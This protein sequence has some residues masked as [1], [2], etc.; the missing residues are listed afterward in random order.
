VATWSFR[1]RP[2]RSRPPSSPPTRSISPRSSA[3]CTSSSVTSGW[4]LPSATSE[5]RL[6]SPATRPSRWSSV[7]SPARN[8]TRECAFDAWMS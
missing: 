8:S 7:S 5:A 1:E 2:A 4:K 6:S 3:P